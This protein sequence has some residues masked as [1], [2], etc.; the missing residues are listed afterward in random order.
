LGIGWETPIAHLILCMPFATTVGNSSLE[1]A[2]GFS[3]ALR[4]WWHLMFPN[5]V[6]QSGLCFKLDNADGM[7]ISINI[8]EFVMA[9][10]NYCA[11]LHIINTTPVTDDPHP[12]LLNITDNMSATNWTIYTCRCSQRLAACLH[13]FSVHC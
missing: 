2:G 11:A 3:I 12:V 1:G 4:F 8:L 10:I 9:I 5:E 13:V 6:V 7:L